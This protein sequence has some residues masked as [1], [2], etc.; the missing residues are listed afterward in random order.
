[1]VSTYYLLSQP[2]LLVA[3]LLTIVYV[4]TTCCYGP[5]KEASID[6]FVI[7]LLIG[8]C[9]LSQSPLGSLARNTLLTLQLEIDK[10][11]YELM[12]LAQ[13]YERPAHPS[14]ILQHQLRG[15]VEKKKEY[16]ANGEGDDHV[17]RQLTNAEHEI[18]LLKKDNNDLTSRNECLLDELKVLQ[19]RRWSV[20][21]EF[22]DKLQARDHNIESLNKKLAD[23]RAAGEAAKQQ[24]LQDS[25]SID[26]A[27]RIALL[28]ERQ[29][30][31]HTLESRCKSH[32]VALNKERTLH[33]DLQARLQ[34]EVEQLRHI[35][36]EHDREITNLNKELQLTH[37]KYERGCSRTAHKASHQQNSATFEPASSQNHLNG[38]TNL[39]EHAPGRLKPTSSLLGDAK[40]SSAGNSAGTGTAAVAKAPT[41]TKNCPDS[42]PEPMEKPE[43]NA[44]SV[45]ANS[46]TPSSGM[47]VLEAGTAKSSTGVAKHTEVMKKCE[48][49]QEICGPQ[50][51]KAGSK[52]KNSSTALDSKKKNKAVKKRE[53]AQQKN[54][55]TQPKPQVK[56][57]TKT[58][59]KEPEAD[60]QK[61]EVVQ[62]MPMAFHTGSKIGRDQALEKA[63]IDNQSEAVKKTTDALQKQHLNKD[64]ASNI[65]E[66]RKSPDGTVPA[67]DDMNCSHPAGVSEDFIVVQNPPQVRHECPRH[68]SK[69]DCHILPIADDKMHKPRSPLKKKRSHEDFQKMSPPDPLFIHLE[70]D[71]P[72]P[73]SEWSESESDDSHTQHIEKRR[74]R[75]PQ[76]T[77]RCVKRAIRSVR[78]KEWA[79]SH[80][81]ILD[82]YL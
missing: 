14:N 58:V 80:P 39:E 62:S 81:S 69:A 51:G 77:K 43:A 46:E 47:P 20:E 12:Q 76:D 22:R 37:S 66:A 7:L 38:G 1:M 25:E 17:K 29:A 40:C 11:R 61:A 28:T 44:A 71:A 48:V 64:N 26:M 65:T 32:E 42:N 68:R 9:A 74:C 45:T 79:A 3:L 21:Q 53:V 31:Q 82:A 24:R 75:S 8:V 57:K 56:Q 23:E 10:T 15:L 5:L 18:H 4:C 50:K 16:M 73:P 2:R 54:E 49:P 19:A 6:F 36:T 33:H 67:L 41:S 52:D 34:A 27:H 78:V 60:Q 72:R 55:A 59:Q 13:S 35:C 30:H 63:R 70:E